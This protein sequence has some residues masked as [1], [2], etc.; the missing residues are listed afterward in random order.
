VQPGFEIVE[1][2]GVRLRGRT[3]DEAAMLLAQA[4]NSE[5]PTI[6]L[7]VIPN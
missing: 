3:H 4:F 5:N 6:E 7:I 1:V 2:D